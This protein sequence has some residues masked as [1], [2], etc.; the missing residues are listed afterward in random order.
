MRKK[1]KKQKIQLKDIS[2]IK[3]M[4]YNNKLKNY[5]NSPN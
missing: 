2:K 3:D 4:T 5:K 1:N